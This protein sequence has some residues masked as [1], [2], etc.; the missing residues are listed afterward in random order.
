LQ[1]VNILSGLARGQDAPERI[2]DLRDFPFVVLLGEP[3]IGKS[4]VDIFPSGRAAPK[5]L[6]L[7]LGRVPKTGGQKQPHTFHRAAMFWSKLH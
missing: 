6:V 3:G 2:S 1:R 5:S 7:S 4:T